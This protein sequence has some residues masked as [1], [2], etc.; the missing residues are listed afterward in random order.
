M[1]YKNFINEFKVRE[2]ERQN[3]I[4]AGINRLENF[5]I[6]NKILF[7]KNNQILSNMTE[8]DI[9]WADTVYTVLISC[10]NTFIPKKIYF[11]LRVQK[12][13]QKSENIPDGQ[14]YISLCHISGSIP[15]KQIGNTFLVSYSE[16]EK[17]LIFKPFCYIRRYS[18]TL[19][20]TAIKTFMKKK[21]ID[22]TPQIVRKKINI[23]IDP[24]VDKIGGFEPVGKGPFNY[25]LFEGKNNITHMKA[26]VILESEMATF[27]KQYINYDPLFKLQMKTW[28]NIL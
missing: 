28:T 27:I 25:N 11:A 15:N 22:V 2:K 12:S 10:D 9:K 8:H 23:D 24:G 26:N 1:N 21:V 6:Y 16:D 3:I 19:K 7:I 4:P 20:A 17:D 5:M 18:E 14:I 13:R